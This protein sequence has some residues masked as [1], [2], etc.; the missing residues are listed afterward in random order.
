MVMKGEDNLEAILKPVNIPNTTT[1]L[2]WSFD[3][4]FPNAN[5]VNLN[6]VIRIS[7]NSEQEYLQE[8]VTYE[9]RQNKIHLHLK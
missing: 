4:L 7:F 5:Y 2:R 9:L 3:R 8:Q 6:P 1:K